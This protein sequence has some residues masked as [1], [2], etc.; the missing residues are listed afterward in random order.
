MSY[1]FL[2]EKRTSITFVCSRS[3]VL[4][5]STYHIPAPGE[6]QSLSKRTDMTH[7]DNLN[8]WSWL[9]G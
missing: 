5:V 2:E 1:N 3:L 6:W 7:L 9:E 4:K 8:L